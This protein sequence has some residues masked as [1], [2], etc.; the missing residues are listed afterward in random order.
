MNQEAT[1]FIA[2]LVATYIVICVAAY[3]VRVN[4]NV[5]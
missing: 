4:L 2:W 1:T 3:H 5:L